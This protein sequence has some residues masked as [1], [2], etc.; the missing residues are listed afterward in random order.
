[1]AITFCHGC[2]EKQ[3]AID[4]LEQENAR[5]RQKLRSE[6]RRGKEGFFGSSTP[7]SKLPVKTNTPAPTTRK[8]RGGK[9]GTSGQRSQ[10]HRGNRCGPGHRHRCGSRE[11]LPVVPWRPGAKG[12]PIEIC[13][14]EP[15]DQSRAGGLSPAQKVLS[16]LS[17]GIPHSVARRAPTESVR[18]RSDYDGGDDALSARNSD[19]ADLRTDWHRPVEPG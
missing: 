8:P 4:R 9:A 5:L 7:S 18:Q 12:V 10:T 3:I 6:E 16:S 15:S 19:G 1:M 14:R 13:H 2:F 11:L 17:Q